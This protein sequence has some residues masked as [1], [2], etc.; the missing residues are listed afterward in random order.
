MDER[1]RWLHTPVVAHAA[2][3]ETELQSHTALSQHASGRG[4]VIDVVIVAVLCCCAV[5]LCCCAVL[6]CC[7][8]VLL[9]CVVLR[10]WVAVCGVRCAVCGSWSQ[11]SEVCPPVGLPNQDVPPLTHC[12]PNPLARRSEE[13]QPAASHARLVMR[14]S[15][16]SP[17]VP[18]PPPP[19]R[20]SPSLIC[21]V[22]TPKQSRPSN[23]HEPL[24]VGETSVPRFCFRFHPIT[25]HS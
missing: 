2:H 18:S 7:C 3:A 24:L 1:A 19:T 15:L 21:T 11:C 22:T 4:F 9:C 23:A 5:L 12:R 10:F 6:L 16:R 20:A 13:P 8:A 14:A 25:N 17:L